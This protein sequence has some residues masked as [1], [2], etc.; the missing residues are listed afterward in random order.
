MFYFSAVVKHLCYVWIYAFVFS[1]FVYHFVK[2]IFYN[3]IKDWFWKFS[4]SD[5]CCLQYENV[6]NVEWTRPWSRGLKFLI[7]SITFSKYGFGALTLGF[8]LFFFQLLTWYLTV[9]NFRC[10]VNFLCHFIIFDV[11]LA[12]KQKYQKYI[13]IPNFENLVDQ[14]KKMNKLVNNKNYFPKNNSNLTEE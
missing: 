4:T 1:F 14:N 7:F 12:I 2:T 3:G 6:N 11:T 8:Q 13:P 9:S 10:H 5:A